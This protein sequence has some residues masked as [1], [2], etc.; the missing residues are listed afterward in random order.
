[1]KTLFNSIKKLLGTVVSVLTFGLIKMNDN[2]TKNC[3]VKMLRVKKEDLV[4]ED[5]KIFDKTAKLEGDKRVVIK[6]IYNISKDLTNI[7]DKLVVARDTNNKVLF[8]ELSNDYKDK[9]AI[10]QEKNEILKA[11]EEAL[12]ILDNESK[13]VKKQIKSI[14]RTINKIEAKQATYETIK[15]VNEVLGD[16]KKNTTDKTSVEE[17]VEDLD[18]DVIRESAKAE[19]IRKDMI[20]ED[21]PI[22]FNNE[23]EMDEFLKSIS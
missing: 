17:L 19:L 21:E 7:K 10:L 1:M 16:M 2:L 15:G 13:V 14:T 23:Q 12:G 6:E 3:R 11:F 22:E 5:K 9:D 18:N 8:T 20:V 4:L